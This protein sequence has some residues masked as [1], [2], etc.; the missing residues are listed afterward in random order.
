MTLRFAPIVTVR[1]APVSVV[2]RPPCGLCVSEYSSGVLE[3]RREQ[4]GVDQPWVHV[5]TRAEVP[6]CLAC[7]RW[8]HKVLGAAA[9]RSLVER[10]PGFPATAPGAPG[11]QFNCDFCGVHLLD[12][13]HVADLIPERGKFVRKFSYMHTGAVRQHRLCQGCWTWAR[14]LTFDPASARGTST[15][16]D[17][18]PPGA[19]LGATALDACSVYL[20]EPDAAVLHDVAGAGQRR[21]IPLAPE[22][23][24]QFG[25]ASTEVLFVG[26]STAGR[27]A[28][29][30]GSLSERAKSRT[31]VVARTDALEDMA[32]AL[33]MGAAEFATSPLTPHQVAAAFDRIQDG[34]DAERTPGK[35]GL[36]IYARLPANLPH[37]GQVIE[38]SVPASEDIRE[39]AWLLRR[40]LRGYDRVGA[41]EAGG[42]EA[43]VYCPDAAV[44]RVLER[45]RTL[46][47]RGVKLQ[48]ADRIESETA[49]FRA[50]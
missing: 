12:E 21:Y 25:G 42:L 36:P 44:P 3:F 16:R 15:R 29:L 1:E 27:A 43:T 38:V 34:H 48:L 46:L 30:V 18:G 32:N 22:R 10:P 8:L 24:R 40:F 14:S 6:V 49:T 28:N 31:V 11:G 7:S 13:A 23:A 4:R 47:G 20:F 26:C 50:A 41:S 19:W 45:L 37:P 35:A 39:M 17:E 5:E 9:D 33:A 2:Y